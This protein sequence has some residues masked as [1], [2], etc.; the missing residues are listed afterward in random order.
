VLLAGSIEELLLDLT[1]VYNRPLRTFSTTGAIARVQPPKIKFTWKTV[2][3]PLLGLVGFFLYLYLF[4]VDLFGIIATAQRADPLIYSA[5]VF[6]GFIEIFFFTA[7]WHALTSHI[8]I[9]LSIKKAFL[10][11]WYG[12]YVDT[13]VPAESISGEVVRAYLV[14]RDKCSSFGKAMASLFMHRVLGMT[15]NVVI[16]I[17]GIVLL[18]I[19][20]NIAK[21]IFDIIVFVAVGITVTIAG[22]MV[23]AFKGTWM[24]KV[25]DWTTRI[26]S[27]VSRGRW[28]LGKY[29][30]G[31][32]EIA[33]HFHGSMIEYRHDLKPVVESFIYLGVTWFFSL[34]IPYLVFCSLGQ[35]IHWGIILIT[36]AIVLAVKSIPVGIPFEVGIPEA[37]MTTLYIALG[38][39]GA[40][41]ATVTIL[42]RVITLWIRFFT[43]FVAQQYL[44]LRS[45]IAKAENEK[46]KNKPRV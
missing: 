39:N 29:R 31:A 9:R 14:V 19:D 35:P 2:L 7:S 44:E 34:V 43:G 1:K 3:L 23:L 24:L 38:V 42:T 30:E 20:G 40:L 46:T 32:I 22:L 28:N 26:I 33:N 4:N 10:Y 21:P 36:A 11:V 8:D 13:I 17:L 5:A 25:L 45:S 37:T 6:C 16:L 27:K 41:A 18:N 15:M 12:I